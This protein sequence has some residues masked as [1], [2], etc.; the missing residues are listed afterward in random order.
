MEQIQITIGVSPD[1]ATEAQGGSLLS[2]PMG[3]AGVVVR[4]LRARRVLAT[5]LELLELCLGGV[6]ARFRR[7]YG[8]E[9]DGGLWVAFG[10]ISVV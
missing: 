7:K 4:E 3:T 1:L 10:Q 2:T 8:E 9:G 5:V 6:S